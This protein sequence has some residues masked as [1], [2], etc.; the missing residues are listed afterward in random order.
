MADVE[1]VPFFVAYAT[2][3][4]RTSKAWVNAKAAADSANL[5]AVRNSN[6]CIVGIEIS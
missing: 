4:K 3:D 2:K 5:M 6:V 1:S